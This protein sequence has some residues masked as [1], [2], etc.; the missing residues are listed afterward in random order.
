[1]S[2]QTKKCPLCAEEI[3]IEAT[4]C[5][6]CGAGFQVAITGYCANCHEVRE[7]DEKGCC[8]QCGGEVLDK[9]VE[10]Q[11]IEE[12][13]ALPAEKP[14]APPPP[15]VRKWGKRAWILAGALLLMAGVLGLAIWSPWDS[16]T[17]DEYNQWPVVFYDPVDAG[18]DWPTRIWVD[19]QVQANSAI[20]DGVFR[21][22]A[23]AKQEYIFWWY[24][25]GQDVSDLYLTTDLKQIGGSPEGPAAASIG[26]RFR[27]I[28][29]E[30]FYVFEVRI[31]RQFSLAIVD[32]GNWSELVESGK[33]TAYHPGQFNEIAIICKGNHMM[34]F[35]NKQLVA[36]AYD[37]RYTSGHVGV[38]AWI[39]NA[40]EEAIFEVDNF[41]LRA[42]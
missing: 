34:A 8:K 21:L 29:N 28:D 42:P 18:S 37:D 13:A 15:T 33:T 19:E 17:L 4:T 12:P 26:V 20:K 24:L 32:D 2:T 3:P 40:G 41:K 1:M 22:Q 27:T 39:P 10:S 30:H 14:A 16:F 11:F 35:V 38:Q 23:K 31:N 25:S 5:E 9:R 6:Y 7:A 36:E